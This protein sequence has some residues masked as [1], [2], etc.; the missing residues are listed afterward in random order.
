MY[1]VAELG[2]LLCAG[3]TLSVA[4]RGT[5]EDYVITRWRWASGVGN[6][7]LPVRN[8]DGVSVR[9][10]RQIN[11][12]WTVIFGILL[13]V[14]CHS[15]MTSVANHSVVNY[16]ELI[17]SMEPDLSRQNFEDLF[18][19]DFKELSLRTLSTLCRL[20]WRSRG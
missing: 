18:R 14:W 1:Y 2:L 8:R 7:A 17:G 15:K 20:S 10:F 4:Y 11:Y 19:E 13:A 12:V 6:V 5:R 9:R 3:I 16:S